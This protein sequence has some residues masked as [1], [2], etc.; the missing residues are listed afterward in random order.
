MSPRRG[1]SVKTES[2]LVVARLGAGGNGVTAVGYRVSFLG[3]ENILKLDGGD[4][5]TLNY[6][7]KK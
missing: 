1:R 4:G 2:G 7:E 3:I 5:T 6:W